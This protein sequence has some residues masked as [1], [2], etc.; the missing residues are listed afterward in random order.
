[1]PT[2]GTN[3]LSSLVNAIEAPCVVFEKQYLA[4]L[5]A[6]REDFGAA[7]ARRLATD[8]LAEAAQAAFAG[9]V[10]TVLVDA[11]KTIPGRIELE[12]GEMRPA[13]PAEPAPGDQLDD[14]AEMVIR[15]GGT[16]MVVTSDKMPTTTG[17]AAIYRF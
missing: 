8:D 12:T 3:Y 9:R 13:G 5:E 2:L 14:L 6:V 1:M 16:V 10:G 7:K 15:T 17:L 4:R 11:D